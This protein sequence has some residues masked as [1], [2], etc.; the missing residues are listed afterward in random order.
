PPLFHF[1]AH[2]DTGRVLFLQ[3]HAIAS[4]SIQPRANRKDVAPQL[5]RK[6]TGFPGVITKRLHWRTLPLGGI[7]R[8]PEHLRGQLIVTVHEYV[9]LYDDGFAQNALHSELPLIDGRPHCF[10]RNAFAAQRC[11]QTSPLLPGTSSVLGYP[12]S[13]SERQIA[14]APRLQTETLRLT[15]RSFLQHETV[16][17]STFNQAALD[18]GRAPHARVDEKKA[19]AV[20]HAK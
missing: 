2:I 12:V 7:H 1:Q 14:P 4:P 11:G 19:S 10:D 9:R 17:Q 3:L 13:L 18:T 16:G 6:N 20:I 15:I 8:A 5:A